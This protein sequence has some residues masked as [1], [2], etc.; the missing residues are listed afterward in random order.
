MSCTRI[1]PANYGD[2]WL[3][4]RVLGCIVV[5]ADEPMELS[6]KDSFMHHVGHFFE[7]TLVDAKYNLGQNRT[8]LAECLWG[9][10]ERND[11][12]FLKIMVQIF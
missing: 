8:M 4:R 7:A 6:T 3:A 5:Q 10:G 12:M 2:T 11:A 1:E 9:R